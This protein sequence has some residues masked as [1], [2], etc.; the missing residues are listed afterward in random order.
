MFCTVGL[1]IQSGILISLLITINS[2]ASFDKVPGDFHFTQ[3]Y[4]YAIISAALSFTTLICVTSHGVVLIKM[5][6]S[7][8]LRVGSTGS[9]LFRQSI[10]LIAYLLLGA[11]LYAHIEDW[12]F[13]DAVFWADFTLLTIGLGGEF[14][15]KTSL[16]RGLL[17]PY[18]IG[19]IVFVALLVVSIRK[20]LLD[21]RSRETDRLVNILRERL[22]KRLVTTNDTSVSLGDEDTFN[23]VRRIPRDAQRRC[24]LTACAFSV[25]ATIILLLCGAS[26]FH[27]AE[28]DHTWTYGVS[29]YFA[30]V[31]LLTIGYGDF[32]PNSDA[33][34]PF[35]VVWSLLSVPVLT[36]FINNS[37]DAV[38]GS[39]RG[40]WPSLMRL[41]QNCRCYWMRVPQSHLPVRASQSRHSRQHRNTVSEGV[42][43]ELCF[44]RE[45]N[46]LK[47]ISHEYDGHSRSQESAAVGIT[48]VD[49]GIH[50]YLMA[51]ELSIIAK[52]LFAEP[53]KKYSYHQWAYYINLMQSTTSH[54]RFNE[55]TQQN[56][57][58]GSA[59]NGGAGP[60][61]T[62][63][64]LHP[65]QWAS[66][67]TPILLP[68]EA[69]WLLSWLS[70]ELTRSL[71][72][73]LPHENDHL[74]L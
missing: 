73:L 37:I 59:R 29:A 11:A 44:R 13:L 43:V 66:Q 62:L 30:Y 48:E 34:K 70:S 53:R 50:C 4:Y 47:S 52:D 39:V 61:S 31:S 45:D 17:L 69:E 71:H 21:G 38:Y 23:L 68:H 36:I 2:I 8:P 55:E 14:T 67:G 51:R 58:P 24:S 6:H 33:S 15:P 16:G 32:I 5:Y 25:I 7:M 60:S 49:L 10:A 57:G 46:F 35:F 18:A 54:R 72:A 9:N 42:N 19:G 63:R 3:A 20:L 1:L 12:S 26:V 28:T 22:E 65:I 74:S 64:S 41:M 56:E 27:V 40:L